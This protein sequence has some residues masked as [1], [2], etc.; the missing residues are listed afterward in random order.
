MRAS[1]AAGAL[2]A[3]VEKYKLTKPRLI[4]G[5]SGSVGT[6]A[7]YAARQYSHIKTVWPNLLANKRLINPY[8]FWNIL[9]VDY[10]VD[11]VFKK[12]A[13]LDLTALHNS[14][15]EYL[16]PTTD[17][18]TGKI[19]YFSNRKQDDMFEAIRAGKALPIISKRIVKI[20]GR[21]YGDTYAS[22]LTELHMEQ[23][24]R[25]GAE[26]IIVINNGMATRFAQT[27]FGL[28]YYWQTKRFRDRYYKYKE[29]S[30]RIKFPQR[31]Q[32][33]RLSPLKQLRVTTLSSDSRLVQE[34]FQQGYEEAATNAELYKFL[35]D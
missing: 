27:T 31:V 1:Y 34:S 2:T 7:Y 9:D 25:R 4:I 14:E 28:W 10:L 13:P 6:A 35:H 11:E 18:E 29:R 3:M 32:F 19:R 16:I 23:A 17:Y 22:T 5:S 30:K 12:Q 15:T 24:V 26:K 21:M 8:R 20:K 33:L